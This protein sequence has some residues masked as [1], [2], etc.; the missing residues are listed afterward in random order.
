MLNC[1]ELF[2]FSE[3]MNKEK[4]VKDLN[5]WKVSPRLRIWK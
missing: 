1:E 5:Q 2:Y 3:T 4:K